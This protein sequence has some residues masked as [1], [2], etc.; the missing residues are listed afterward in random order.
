MKQENS[1]DIKNNKDKALRL[2][3]NE[4]RFLPKNTT[5]AQLLKP[6]TNIIFYY[7]GLVGGNKKLCIT[8]FADTQLYLER[9][10]QTRN[11]E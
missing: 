11:M 10:R 8:P 5:K 1:S 9:A 6:P 3:R 2:V 4:V 7:N